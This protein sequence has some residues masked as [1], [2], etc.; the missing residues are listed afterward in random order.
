MNN[1]VSVKLFAFARESVGKN[2]VEIE[3]NEHSTISDALEVLRSKFPQLES[4]LF[5][6]NGNLKSDYSIFVNDTRVEKKRFGKYLLRPKD[7][8]LIY[9]PVGGG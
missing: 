1:T 6:D 8:L 9:P 5:D 4:I 3:V 7:T 2:L